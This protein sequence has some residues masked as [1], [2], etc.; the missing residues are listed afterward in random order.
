MKVKVSYWAKVERVFEVDDKFIGAMEQGDNGDYT[1]EA[2]ALSL[3]CSK[4]CTN[5]IFDKHEWGE[6]EPDN[7]TITTME[8]DVIFES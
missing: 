3:E 1:E 2:N 6:A 5:I 7:I 8:N 4:V